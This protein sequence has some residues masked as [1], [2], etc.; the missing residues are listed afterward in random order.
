MAKN[1]AESISRCLLDI[2][3]GW[4]ENILAT[5]SLTASA[6]QAAWEFLN[7]ISSLNIS[8][9]AILWMRFVNQPKL[10]PDHQFH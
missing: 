2:V 9:S 3:S 1:M 4:H 10:S 8:V 6:Y 5:I 7:L